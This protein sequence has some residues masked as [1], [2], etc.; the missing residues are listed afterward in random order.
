MKARLED[1]TDA[2]Q[3][4]FEIRGGHFD[5][6]CQGK[7]NFICEYDRSIYDHEKLMGYRKLG[8]MHYVQED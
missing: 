1:P 5:D 3:E 6:E 2:L 8:V 4:Y 7:C